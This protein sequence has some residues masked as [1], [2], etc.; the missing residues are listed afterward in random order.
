MKNAVRKAS[1]ALIAIFCAAGITTAGIEVLNPGIEVLGIE[2]L[3]GGQ[4]FVH[5]HVTNAPEGAMLKAYR[6]GVCVE[7]Q[8]VGAD[9]FVS[10]IFPDAHPDNHLSLQDADGIEVLRVNLDGIEVL[11]GI[12]DHL[13]VQ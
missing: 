11:S 2:V 13:E 1:L 10:V 7:M 5:S 6:A 9:G 4:L 12:E 3:S 8:I